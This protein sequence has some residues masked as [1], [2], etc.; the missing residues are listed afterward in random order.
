[1]E[2]MYISHQYVPWIICY[3]GIKHKFNQQYIFDKSIN[4]K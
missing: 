2:E 4:L 3:G 1:V